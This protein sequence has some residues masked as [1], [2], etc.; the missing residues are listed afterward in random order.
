[1]PGADAS[2][3]LIRL[4]QVIGRDRH[5]TAVAHLHLAVE[6]QE[7]F[8]LP[9]FFWTETSAR[10]HQHQRIASLQLRERAVLAAVVRKLVVGK[11][12][13]GNDVGSHSANLYPCARSHKKPATHRSAG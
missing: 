9:P 6:V 5:E 8:V 4:E 3:E 13:A 1:A 7:P 10:E 12:C 2:G 11:H